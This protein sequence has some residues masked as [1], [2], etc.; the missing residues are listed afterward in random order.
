M[1]SLIKFVLK[2]EIFTISEFP[3]LGSIWSC[4]GPSPTR[5]PRPAASISERQPEL[6]RKPLFAQSEQLVFGVCPISS[7]SDGRDRRHS[8]ARLLCANQPDQSGRRRCSSSTSGLCRR[9]RSVL[10]AGRSG[11]GWQEFG[12]VYIWNELK[13]ESF[14]KT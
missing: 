11:R 8:Q 7:I 3:W 14:L 13:H 10:L 6:Q 12:S 4:Q 5:H 9:Y 2:F 1:F